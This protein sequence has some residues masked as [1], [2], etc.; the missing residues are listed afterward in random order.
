MDVW[1]T[2]DAIKEEVADEEAQIACIGPAGEKL[3][4]FASIIVNR[5]RAAGRCGL[6]AVMGSK[7]LKA[8]AV[9]GTGVIEIA[10]PKPSRV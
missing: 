5:G 10:G 3:V 4:K 1:D 9:R 2:N 6:G 7:N 8:I